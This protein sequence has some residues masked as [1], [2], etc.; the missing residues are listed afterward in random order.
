MDKYNLLGQVFDDD[1]VRAPDAAQGRAE[2]A[3]TGGSGSTGRQV[4]DISNMETLADKFAKEAPEAIGKALRE[5][6]FSQGAP[7]DDF[8]DQLARDL[9]GFFEIINN[10]V[11]N[12]ARSAANNKAFGASLRQSAFG[13]G[14]PKAADAMTQLDIAISELAEPVQDFT[15]D[16]EG[17]EPAGHSAAQITKGVVAGLDAIGQMAPEVSA[18]TGAFSSLIQGDYLGAA[19]QGFAALTSVIGPSTEAQAEYRREME[20]T[21]SLLEQG[22]STSQD[23]IEDLFSGDV[24]SGQSDVLGIMKEWFDFFQG[25]GYGDVSSNADAVREMFD[26]LS[27]LDAT[28]TRALDPTAELF[29]ITGGSFADFRAQVDEAF[30][31]SSTFSEIAEMFFDTSDAFD[32]LRDSTVAAKT[33]VGDL[34]DAEKAATRLRVNAQEIGLR[35]TLGQDFKQAGSDQFERA[36]A[37]KRFEGAVAALRQSA[38]QMGR[39]SGGVNVGSTTTTTGSTTPGSTTTGGTTTGNGSILPTTTITPQVTVNPVNLS[40]EMLV[41]V[42]TEEQFETYY[43]IDL[44]PHISNPLLAVTQQVSDNVAA[45]KVTLRPWHLFSVPSSKMWAGYWGLFLL[46]RA[47]SDTHGP[48]NVADQIKKNTIANKQTINPGDMFSFPDSSVWQGYW[49]DLLPIVASVGTQDQTGGF[50]GGYGPQAAAAQIKKNTIDNKQTIN[51]TDMFS[52]ADSS[53]WRG[54]WDDLLP[55]IAS[56]GSSNPHET[57]GGYGPQAAAS[58]V[59]GNIN[60][61]TILPTDLFKEIGNDSAGHFRSYWE[62]GLHKYIVGENYGPNA[63]IQQ[64]KDT[65]NKWT[66]TPSEIIG[67]VPNYSAWF[68][69]FKGLNLDY[70]LFWGLWYALRG[71]SVRVNLVDL[72]DFN[73]SGVQ[74]AIN[75]AVQDAIND[76]QYD[77][78]LGY[79][80]GRA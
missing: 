49:D 62:Q 80:S 50:S 17:M 64:T 32:D 4:F 1:L 28:G 40:P 41:T 61:H 51:P 25:G 73:A 36:K 31:S 8:A 75:T 26:R 74:E 48:D 63:A 55:A 59:V 78:S 7:L 20:K 56:A 58:Q 52:Y 2:N 42:P 54:F 53:V 13:A 14:A 72:I 46:K 43:S 45:N 18:F 35:T 30:G 27:R 37:F 69:H 76:R 3:F 60:P 24:T 10:E 12:A 33:A 66:L 23:I 65:I 79:G 44:L 21:L 29:K 19:V 39:G 11:E 6:A 57:T 67:G 5:K 68:D 16:L 22:A 70:H 38:T 71:I 77:D 15:L 34:T 47:D 9:D